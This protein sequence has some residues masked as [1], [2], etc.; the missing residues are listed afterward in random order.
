VTSLDGL[1]VTV[2]AIGFIIGAVH[3]AF[4]L[5]VREGRE[6]ELNGFVKARMRP[7]L[8]EIFF[9]GMG[10]VVVGVVVAVIIFGLHKLVT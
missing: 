7:Y 2:I 9:S 3:G 8:A 10:G 4:E 1:Y 5:G 6:V